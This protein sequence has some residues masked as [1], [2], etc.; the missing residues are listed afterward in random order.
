MSYLPTMDKLRGLTF[1]QA[2]CFGK[3][4]IGASYAKRDVRSNRLDSFATCAVCGGEAMSSH[5]EPPL[6]MGGRNRQFLLSTPAGDF[7]LRPAL[8]ALCGSG[9]TGCHGDRHNSLRVLR[10]R[11]V[12][13]RGYYQEQWWNGYLL[14]HGYEPHDPGLYEFGYWQLTRDGVPFK[15]IRG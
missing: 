7:T 3:P 12:W 9:T 14:T 4:H 1:E 2:E 15:A 11:W 6:G 5:H 10:F 8:I 13:D